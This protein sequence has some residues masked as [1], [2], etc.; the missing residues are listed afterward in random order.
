MYDVLFNDISV[1]YLTHC[2]DETP[3]LPLAALI[4]QCGQVSAV[5]LDPRLFEFVMKRV[6]MLCVFVLLWL[7]NHV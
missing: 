5:E 1:L 7:M 2:S 4:W 6:E 3:V